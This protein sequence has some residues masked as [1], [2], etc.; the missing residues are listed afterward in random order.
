M[1]GSK[2]VSDFLTDR[3]RSRI[4]KLSA[5]ALCDDEHIAAIIG[6]RPSALHAITSATRRVLIV[7]HEPPHA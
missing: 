4:E 1:S 6:E 2:L 3:K 5:L 7:R